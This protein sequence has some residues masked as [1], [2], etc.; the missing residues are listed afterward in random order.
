MIRQ[1]IEAA[2]QEDQLVLGMELPEEGLMPGR[3]YI[4]PHVFVTDDPKSKL[5]QKEI[6]GPV[7]GLI[8][9]W[10][11]EHAL[12]LANDGRYRLTGGV[13][14]RTLPTSRKHVE[15]PRQEPVPQPKHHGSHRG[16]PAL[17]WSRHER[18][19]IQSRRPGLPAA[20]CG[21]TGDYGLP[22]VAASPRGLG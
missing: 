4:A 9:A 11:F 2:K 3:S 12:E 15:I 13:Y 21:T 22:C 6:F 10:N 16:P 7:L 17:R 8:R 14:S 19:W 18:R 5:M 20:V 1:R